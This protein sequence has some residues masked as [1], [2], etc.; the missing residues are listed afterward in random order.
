M[1]DKFDELTKG[2]AQS[3][4]R[5]RPLKKLRPTLA[6]IALALLGPVMAHANDFKLG[7]LMSLSDSDVLHVCSED[8]PGS[9]KIE[10]ES[11]IGVNPKNPKNLVVCWIEGAFRAN[12]SAVS[13]DGGKH[14]E[15]KLIPGL[16]LCTG[17]SFVGNPDPWL[18]FGPDGSLYFI[19]LGND[20]SAGRLAVLTCKSLDG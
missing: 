13:M 19:T 14:W 2:L 12:A 7:P 20:S 3:V 4:M 9:S 15:S 1:N 10:A 5:R 6:C 18:S 17:G 11:C 8:F 16:S